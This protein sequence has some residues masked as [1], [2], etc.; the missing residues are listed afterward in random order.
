[1]TPTALPALTPLLR[2]GV[3][4]LALTVAACATAP[5]AIVGAP[6][7]TPTGA[8]MHRIVVAPVTER[9]DLPAATA[10]LDQDSRNALSEFAAIY[11][12]SGHGALVVAAPEGAANAAAAMQI[13]QQ[14]RLALAANG[15][16]F[17]DI[18]TSTYAAG[19][20]VE[21]TVILSFERFEAGAADCAPLYRQDLSDV[22]QNRPYRSFGCA[23]QANLVAMIA[24]PADLARPRPE[25][26]ADAGRRQTVL[27]KYRRGD[28]THANR[29][30]DERVTVST[31]AR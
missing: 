14:A 6:P 16:P 26:P 2:L 24:D 15:V 9:L 21:A 7:A 27:D 3:G 30:G 22:S 10:A 4:A 18:A 23:S 31:V 20:G 5:D 25:D 12:R 17:D 11:R 29:S 19:E 8:D 1:M 28:Q 13:A